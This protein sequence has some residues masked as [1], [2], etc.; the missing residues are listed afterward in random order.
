M[1][2][3]DIGGLGKRSRSGGSKDSKDSGYILKK[4][5]TGFLKTENEVERKKDIKSHPSF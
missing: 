4:T 1:Y 2:E 3:R 5:L